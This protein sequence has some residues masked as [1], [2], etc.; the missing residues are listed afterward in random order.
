MAERLGGWD[1]GRLHD[2][3]GGNGD[4]D[5][6]AISRHQKRFEYTEENTLHPGDGGSDAQLFPALSGIG[7]GERNYLP[8]KLKK[9]IPPKKKKNFGRKKTGNNNKSPVAQVNTTN[10]S[11]AT[12]LRP[13]KPTGDKDE[14]ASGVSVQ[15]LTTTQLLRKARDIL[16]TKENQTKKISELKFKIGH[17]EWDAYEK[18]QVIDPMIKEHFQEIEGKYSH[19]EQVIASMIKEHFQEIEVKDDRIREMAQLHSTKIASTDR[20]L[21]DMVNKIIADK[22]KSNTVSVFILCFYI[23]LAPAIHCHCHFRCHCHCH[24]QLPL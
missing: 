3:R 2:D 12:P 17:P 20:K 22:K 13:Q 18:D 10:A 9:R 1:G 16:Q 6:N 7:N 5:A 23:L 19:K 15:E 11:N 14:P 8:S 4:G 21:R 24:L